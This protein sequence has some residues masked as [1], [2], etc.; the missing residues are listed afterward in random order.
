MQNVV[1]SKT[2]A[3]VILKFRVN[4]MWIGICW[5]RLNHVKHGLTAGYPLQC[6]DLCSVSEHDTET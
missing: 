6:M 5:W 3:R 2:K 1:F 4:P